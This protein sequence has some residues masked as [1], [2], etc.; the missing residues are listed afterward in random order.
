MFFIAK[1]HTDEESSNVFDSF[2]TSSKI[3]IIKPM[4]LTFNED[5]KC[6]TQMYVY[7]YKKR[8][9]KNERSHLKSTLSMYK[10][11]HHC[12]LLNVQSRDPHSFI[13]GIYNVKVIVDA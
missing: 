7:N 12:I 11:R 5:L 2:C 13:R 1:I 3:F 10:I 4:Y 9:I 8:R 6:V